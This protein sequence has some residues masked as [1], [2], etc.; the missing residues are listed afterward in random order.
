MARLNYH[1]LYYFWRVATEGNL[2]RV[3]ESIPVAQSALSSQI[4]QLED[5]F[6]TP[7]FFREGRRLATT[8]AGQRVLT[9]ANDIFSR[10]EELESARRRGLLA[11]VQ[12]LK[13]GVLTTLSRN[14]IDG[15]IAPL[16]ADPVVQLTIRTDTLG[17]LLDGLAKHQLDVALTNADVRG[18]DEQIWQSQ[19]IAQR[20]VSV[21][22]PAGGRP[23][24]RFPKGFEQREWILPDRDNEIRRAFEG[25]CARWQFEPKVKA[26]SNDMAMLRLLA[27]NSGALAVL[28]K[29]VVRDEIESKLLAEYL[30]LPNLNGDFYAI[31]IR[32]RHVP[33]ALT[34]MLAAG[35]QG[36]D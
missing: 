5:Y 29:V 28:P 27:R 21:V 22:G 36:N 18:G 23:R 12:V 3:A 35:D 17:G 25:F 33:P 6:G 9:Y 20:P 7:L 8:E 10:G 15:L 1:H 2:T 24:S 32:R 16:I 34:R 30:P 31:T 26:E 4:R 13:I 14:F 19:L 11:D